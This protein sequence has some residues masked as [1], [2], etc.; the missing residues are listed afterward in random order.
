MLSVVAHGTTER[1]AHPKMWIA[2]RVQM[3]MERRIAAR[4]SALGYENFV[5]VRREIHQWNDRRERID[6]VVLPT[7]VFLRAD[8]REQQALLRLSFINYLIG[9]PGERRAAAIPDIQME[10]FRRMVQCWE[11]EVNIEASPLAVG[12]VVV[13]TGG[14]LRGLCGELVRMEEGQSHVIVRIGALGCASID[15]PSHLVARA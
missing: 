13:I 2:A 1:E 8:E 12:E 6:R 11:G 3:C 9:Y 4:L 10:Q 15:I 7:V 5:P 14:S